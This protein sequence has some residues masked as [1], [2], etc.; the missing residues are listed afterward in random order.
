MDAVIYIHGLGG[1]AEE[2]EHY[3]PLFPSCD[4]IGIE[5]KGSSPWEAGRELKG[6]VTGIRDSYERLILIAVSI[7]AFFA[8]NADI[9]KDISHAFFISPVADMEKLI[10]GMMAG[11]GVT[12]Q[13]LREKGT[14]HTDLGEDL[15]WE[16]LSYVREHPLHWDVPTDILYGSRDSLTSIDTMADFAETHSASLTVMDEGEHWFHTQSQMQF[17]DDWIRK[18]ARL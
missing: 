1:S 9:E 15:S 4:V 10:S 8:M 14:I 13:E 17:L 18:K 12:E 2:S 5:Y 16:Y 11:S 6:A 7:G 3:R